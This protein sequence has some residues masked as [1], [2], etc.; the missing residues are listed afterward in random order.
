MKKWKW[1]YKGPVLKFNT[2]VAAE[3]EMETIA[4]SKQK[5]IAQMTYRFKKDHNLVPSTR[6]TI[7]EDLVVMDASQVYMY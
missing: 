1:K 3:F 5:A 6:I 7:K 2:L 4:E